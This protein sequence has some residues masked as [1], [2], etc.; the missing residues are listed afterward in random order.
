MKGKAGKVSSLA[1]LTV[2]LSRMEVDLKRAS[3]VCRRL[4]QSSRDP[5]MLIGCYIIPVY[6]G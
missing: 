1:T 6:V 4:R 5:V 2:E 3:D